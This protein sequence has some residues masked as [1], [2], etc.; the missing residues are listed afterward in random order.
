MW[1]QVM[2][3]D[4]LRQRD[5]LPYPTGLTT[6]SDTSGTML[7]CIRQPLK[8]RSHHNCENNV[9]FGG[10]TQSYKLSYQLE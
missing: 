5:R 3:S 6:A 4:W 8:S 1:P 9:T 10:P 7:H 2:S